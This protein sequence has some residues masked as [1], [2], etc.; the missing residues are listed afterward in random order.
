[1]FVRL[2][3]RSQRF[4]QINCAADQPFYLDVRIFPDRIRLGQQRATGRRQSKTPVSAVMLI[5]RN[6]Q[7][8]ASFER[9]EVGCKRRSVHGEKRRNAAERWRLGPV[10]RHQQRKLT[11]GEIERPQHIVE[12]ARQRACCPMHVQAQ[13][14]VAHVMRSG[15]RQVTI[16]CSTV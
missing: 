16:F 12:T 10:K 2:R 3:Q 4:A 7:E 8:P 9:L 15:E 13:A 6:L 5:D 11:I 14:I 1:M